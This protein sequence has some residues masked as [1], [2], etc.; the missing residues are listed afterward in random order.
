MSRLRTEETEESTN[1]VIEHF[2]LVIDSLNEPVFCL[3]TK[4]EILH[5]NNAAARICGYGPQELLGRGVKQLIVPEDRDS[6]ENF[7]NDLLDRSPPSPGN[8]LKLGGLRKGGA[9][10]PME[11]LLTVAVMG[12]DI[13]ITLLMHD[14]SAQRSN[15]SAHRTAKNYRKLIESLPGSVFLVNQNLDVVFG[16]QRAVGLLNFQ[17][18]KQLM[19]QNFLELIAPDCREVLESAMHRISEDQPLCQRLSLIKP[20]LTYVP[21]DL[22]ASLILGDNRRPK[23]FSV[24]VRESVDDEFETISAD[25]FGELES[26]LLGTVEAITSIIKL[27][28]QYLAD[29]QERVT[30]LACAIAQEMQLSNESIKG[31][32]VA[33]NLH[34]LGKLMVPTKI[35]WKPAKLTNE[36]FTIIK[37]HPRIS[38]EVIQGIEFPWPVAQA[39]VQ[40][41]ERMDG[42]GYPD[43]VSGS[44]ISVEARILAI[45]DVM[46]AMASYRPYRAGL[47]VDAALNEIV[48]KTKLFDPE[49]AKYCTVLFKEKRCHLL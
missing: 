38:H 28:D 8:S 23:G 46:E 1:D 30:K 37:K 44:N 14:L 6:Y 10:F 40:H 26:A 39:V 20:D 9:R 34:D 15:E 32:Q 43:G 45:A 31:L 41:H 18:L 4:S 42:S 3:D 21:V 36:E 19:G 47:G 5:Y 7:L 12:A 11:M 2:K 17:S 22:S 27:K 24:L 35:L 16:N 13:F 49:I 33:C 29:H 48:T 25:K